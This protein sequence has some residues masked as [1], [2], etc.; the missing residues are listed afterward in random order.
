MN[1]KLVTTVALLTL[2][3]ASMPSI[4]A[5]GQGNNGSGNSA[6]TTES[7]GNSAFGK[8][9]GKAGGKNR[10]VN[11]NA[12]AP[13]FK[14]IDTDGDGMITEEEFT[15]FRQSRITEREEEQRMLRNSIQA[16][17]FSDLDSDGDGLISLTEFQEHQTNSRANRQ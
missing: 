11:Q 17:N 9:R 4:A 5:K 2:S 1:I 15:T 16:R 6:N 3:I 10:Q 14:T 7:P 8:T 12:Q 13:Q